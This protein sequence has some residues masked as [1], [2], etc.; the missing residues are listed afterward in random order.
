MGVLLMV[1]LLLLYLVA[2]VMLL[3]VAHGKVEGSD[4]PWLSLLGG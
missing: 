2:M 4:K 1:C 3:Y